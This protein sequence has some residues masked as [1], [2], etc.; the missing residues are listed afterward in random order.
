MK[1][2]VNTITKHWYVYGALNESP[3]KLCMRFDDFNDCCICAT[4]HEHGDAY[5]SH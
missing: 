2:H 5:F 4:R 1:A 3:R